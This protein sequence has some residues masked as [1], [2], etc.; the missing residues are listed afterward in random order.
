MESDS[1]LEGAAHHKRLG[2]ENTAHHRE[3]QQAQ[4]LQ[5]LRGAKPV[6]RKRAAVSTLSKHRDTGWRAH[7]LVTV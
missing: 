1:N 2:D 5:T 4:P 7:T 3:G 6:P